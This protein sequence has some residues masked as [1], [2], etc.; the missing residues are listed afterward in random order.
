MKPSITTCPVL[1]SWRINIFGDDQ[2]DSQE[3]TPLQL[4]DFSQHETL[5]A[6]LSNPDYLI[7]QPIYEL[8]HNY[9]SDGDVD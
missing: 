2:Y 3:W 5:D 6:W 8:E 9:L 7:E 1:Q 4:Y